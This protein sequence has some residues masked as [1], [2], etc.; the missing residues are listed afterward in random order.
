MMLVTLKSKSFKGRMFVLG[1]PE[2]CGVNGR[3]TD[4]TTISLPIIENHTQ[5]NRCDVVIARSLNS[6]RKL[7]TA[8][9]VVQ[10]HPI[11]QTVDD[12]VTKVSCA[13]GSSPR[14]LFLGSKPQNITLDASF[15]VAEPRYV[16]NIHLSCLYIKHIIIII[17][18]SIH[19]T[20]YDDGGYDTNG[21][22]GSSNQVAK[23]RILEVGR[24]VKQ[25]SEVKLGDELE[26]RIDV[27]HPYS[28]KIVDSNYFYNFQ[29]LYITFFLDATYLRAGHLVA[30]S[31]DGLDSLLLLDWR[32][33]PP[34]PS[35]FPILNLTPPNSMT[36]RFKA[37]RFPSSPILRF[38]LMMMFCDQPCKPVSINYNLF[39]SL[40]Y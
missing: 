14:P 37:F 27:N 30:S 34:E 10:H 8:V 39:L 12:R 13:V 26:L 22:I 33:C 7:A 38:S 2:E 16:I 20:I 17:Y 35:T 6:N 5:R 21:L 24:N 29:V 4:T 36:A 31:G 1:R 18:F 19:N 23:M 15:G 28:K 25:V 32:G 3:H 11:I 40:I 9:V